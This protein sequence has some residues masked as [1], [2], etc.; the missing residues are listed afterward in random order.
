MVDRSQHDYLD[1]RKRTMLVDYA[2]REMKM[3][4]RVVVANSHWVAVVPFWALWTFEVLLLPL[5]PVC[6]LT[7]LHERGRILLAVITKELLTRYDNLFQTSF[8]YSM[9]GMGRRSWKATKPTGSSMRIFTLRCCDRPPS[10]SLWSDTK[11]L[12]RLSA[13]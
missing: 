10:K 1:E 9:G 11:C 13:T 7:D 3:G 12:A 4:E 5:E 8:P 6:R 2:Q